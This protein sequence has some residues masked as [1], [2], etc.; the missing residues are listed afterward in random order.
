MKTRYAW[1]V[2]TYLLF[3]TSLTSLSVDAMSVRR[4]NPL[5]IRVII[6][7]SALPGENVTVFIETTFNG[8][9]VNGGLGRVRVLYTDG[10]QVKN[11]TLQTPK[12]FAVG[13]YYTNYTIPDNATGIYLIQAQGRFRGS[14]TT[15]VAGITIVHPVTEVQVLN[16]RVSNLTEA[17]KSLNDVVRSLSDDVRT[18]TCAVLGALAASV[19]MGI[20]AVAIS[21]RKRP[22]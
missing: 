8:T 4:T 2:L 5:T 7:T 19:A 1:T 6:P 12:R 17:V 14:R 11:Q 22:S 15:G 3:L 21:S 20:F 10:G 9:L 18:L 13:L 16:S